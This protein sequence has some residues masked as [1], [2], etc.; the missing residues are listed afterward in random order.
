MLCHLGKENI[1]QGWR[2][3]ELLGQQFL[4]A[5]NV[6]DKLRKIWSQ[7]LFVKAKA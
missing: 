5:D 7:E 2:E 4:G 6:S 3:Q 1:F